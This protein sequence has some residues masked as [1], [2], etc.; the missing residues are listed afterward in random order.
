MQVIGISAKTLKGLE[1][2]EE[3]VIQNNTYIMYMIKVTMRCS[4]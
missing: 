2:R 1:L 4:R 3:W